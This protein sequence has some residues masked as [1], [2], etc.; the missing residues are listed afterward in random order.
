MKAMIA[1]IVILVLPACTLQQVKTKLSSA[2]DKALEVA[3][4]QICENSTVAAILR[5]Y[6][7]SPAEMKRWRDFCN[8]VSIELPVR[9]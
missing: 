2:G 9:P 6:G 8:R 4:R 1:I 5:R 3:E 7:K